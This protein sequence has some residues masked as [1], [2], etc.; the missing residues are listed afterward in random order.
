M[1]KTQFKLIINLS[2]SHLRVYWRTWLNSCNSFVTHCYSS[3]TLYLTQYCIKQI[4]HCIALDTHLHRYVSSPH[5]T[6]MMKAMHRYTAT[7][8]YTRWYTDAMSHTLGF[9]VTHLHTRVYKHCL[10]PA[11]VGESGCDHGLNTKSKSSVQSAS[12][13]SKSPTRCSN[14]MC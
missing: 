10:S 13:N 7:V 5:S 3:C 11:L 9:N 1:N 2:W 14:L 12:I 8:G 4:N 6:T